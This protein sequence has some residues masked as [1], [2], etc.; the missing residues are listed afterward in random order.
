MNT[1]IQKQKSKKIKTLGGDEDVP[2]GEVKAKIKSLVGSGEMAGEDER[3]GF[4]D[5]GGEED[6][7]DGDDL[8]EDFFKPLKAFRE[9][10]S[11]NQF[12][13]EVKAVAAAKQQKRKD[14]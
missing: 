9:D 3:G 8:G 10:V 14:K 13:E 2:I 5:M 12:Y 1:M 6:D 11:G 7:E 4:A